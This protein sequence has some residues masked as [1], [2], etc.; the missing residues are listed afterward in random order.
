[1]RQVTYSMGCS[2]DGYVVGPDGGFDW[3]EPDEEVFAAHI[4]ELRGTSVHLLGRRL[5]ETM[6]YWETVDQEPGTDHST[7]EW[8]RMWRELPKVVFSST[9]TGVTGTNTR[10]ATGSLADEIGRLRS[11]PGEEEIAIGGAV[12]A[13]DAA[14]EGLIDEYRPFV[15]PV[16]LGGGR[17]YFPELER[18]VDLELVSSRPFACGVVAW[19]YRVVR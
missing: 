13:A 4:E 10:L 8:A 16:L 5:Y 19:R 18:R 2:L 3:S 17:P 14:D 12:L 6:L 11:E 15:Y 9:L 1:M 7:T